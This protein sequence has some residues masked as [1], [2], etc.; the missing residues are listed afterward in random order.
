MGGDVSW[1]LVISN[2]QLVISNNQLTSPTP[3]TLYYYLPELVMGLVNFQDWL[4]SRVTSFQVPQL[5]FTR[6]AGNLTRWHFGSGNSEASDRPNA[7]IQLSNLHQSALKQL[8][9]DEHVNFV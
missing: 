7:K 5:T 6:G 9:L 2:N 8:V 4:E 1:L 3:N